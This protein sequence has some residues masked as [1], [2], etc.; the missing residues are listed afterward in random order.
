MDFG[1]QKLRKRAMG[2]EERAIEREKLERELRYFRI[3]AR[4]ASSYPKWLRRVRRAVG[5]HVADIARELD[6]N[7]SVIYRLEESEGRKSIS[8]RAMEK[9]AGA[10]GCKLVY[11]IVPYGGK[12]ILELAER[13]RWKRKLGKMK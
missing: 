13:Q 1:G 3:A 11:G 5:V 9:M 6:V 8:L 12:T 10:M 7:K 4:K 2:S